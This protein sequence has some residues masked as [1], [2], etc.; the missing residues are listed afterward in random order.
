MTAQGRKAK[1]GLLHDIGTNVRRANTP[2]AYIATSF[3]LDHSHRYERNGPSRP[4]SQHNED[5]TGDKNPRALRAFGCRTQDCHFRFYL[6]AA[7]TPLPHSNVAKR[8]LTS[9]PVTAGSIPAR[10][11]NREAKRGLLPSLLLWS[12]LHTG[13]FTQLRHCLSFSNA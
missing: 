1:G 6:A 2:E 4:Y 9:N 5:G 12:L 11:T 10:R 3:P 13:I 7:A 8:W